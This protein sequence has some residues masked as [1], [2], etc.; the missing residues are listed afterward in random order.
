MR[1]FSINVGKRRCIWAYMFR[2]QKKN[3]PKQSCFNI[4][5]KRFFGGMG[6]LTQVRVRYGH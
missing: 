5:K 4:F 1:Y 3:R 2:N 6:G